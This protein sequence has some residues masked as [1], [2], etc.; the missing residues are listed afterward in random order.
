MT[1]AHPT[2]SS[3]R[4]IAIFRR[5]AF[6]AVFSALLMP[7]GMTTATGQVIVEVQEDWKL[8]V[9]TPD[10]NSSAPQAT[11]IMSPYGHVEGLHVALE[12]NQQTYPHYTPGGVQLH[13]WEGDYLLKSERFPTD[14]VLNTPG[15]TITWTQRMELSGS[16]LI[17]DIDNAVSESWGDFG[18]NSRLWISK[19]TPLTNLIEY[20][21]EVSVRHSGVGYAANRVQRLVLKEVRLYTTTGLYLKDTTERVVYELEP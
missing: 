2:D 17:F 13:T 11:C 14:V 20:S 19:D 4:T 16:K 15:E 6:T 18:S 5:T 7:L 21:P 9:A 12:L 8:V 3:A 1:H 10:G